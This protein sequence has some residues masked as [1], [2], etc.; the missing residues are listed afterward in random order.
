MDGNEFLPVVAPEERELESPYLQRKSG[1]LL[2]IPHFPT[3]R[4]P[5]IYLIGALKNPEI[6]VI[7]KL[8]REDGFE[9]FDDWHEAGPDADSYWQAGEIY[10]GRSYREALQGHHAKCVFDFD[11]YHLDRSSMGV[12]ILPAGKSGHLELGYLS[13]QGKPTFVLF[14][15]EPEKYDVMYKFAE[16]IF[17]NLEEMRSYLSV[18]YST[19]LKVHYD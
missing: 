12:L 19:P 18:V 13:G 17:M 9:V 15:K 2:T 16:E 10:R 11:N 5:V 8:L 6:P 7:G 4:V 14:D 3:N 1:N